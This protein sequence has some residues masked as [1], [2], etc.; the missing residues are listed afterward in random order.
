[1]T[2][3]N[4]YFN[5]NSNSNSNPHKPFAGKRIDLKDTRIGELHEK[6]IY[7]GCDSDDEHPEGWKIYG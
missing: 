5:S 1:M 7:D 6:I 4:N 3:P 2:K